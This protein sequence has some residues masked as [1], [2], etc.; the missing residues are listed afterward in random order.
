MLSYQWVREGIAAKIIE[1]HWCS[2]NQ[3]R[4]EIL[5]INWDYMELKDTIRELFDYKGTSYSTNQIDGLN[6][7]EGEYVG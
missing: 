2:S 5:S 6:R 7:Q 1:F 3:N 4:S